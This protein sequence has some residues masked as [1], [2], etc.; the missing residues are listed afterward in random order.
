M[1]I[2]SEF[3]DIVQADDD[4]EQKRSRL[5]RYVFYIVLVFVAFG[6]TA[7]IAAP[8]VLQ[9]VV[10]WFVAT[11]ANE[12]NIIYFEAI[13]GNNLTANSTDTYPTFNNS[14]VRF[15][16]LFNDTDT[17][18]WHTMFVCN[19]TAGNY[20]YNITLGEPVFTCGG[21]YQY[22]NYSD[23]FVTDNPLYCDF[24]PVGFSNQTQNF[25]LYVLDSGEKLAN[26]SGTFVVNR[27]PYIN[28]TV[29]TII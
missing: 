6:I 23:V 17:S 1:F 13:S 15:N 21:S 20:T 26:V 25:T 16:V 11:G 8:S 3:D 22:C 12:P 27:P 18:D 5:E 19:G 29:V 24:R 4:I 9:S 14:Y 10:Y 28:A 2:V 7:A